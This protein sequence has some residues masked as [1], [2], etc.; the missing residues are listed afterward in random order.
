MGR[1]PAPGRRGWPLLLAPLLVLQ[2]CDMVGQIESTVEAATTGAGMQA[3]PNLALSGRN[4]CG[5]EERTEESSASEG[6]MHRTPGSSQDGVP[7][8]RRKS[9]CGTFFVN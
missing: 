6:E 7:S 1:R 5:V 9:G 4:W 8:E 2:G 3:R